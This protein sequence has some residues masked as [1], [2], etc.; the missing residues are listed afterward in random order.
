MVFDGETFYGQD[1]MDVL[2][3]R[4]RQKGLQAKSS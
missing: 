4:M 2:L 1:R 3:W